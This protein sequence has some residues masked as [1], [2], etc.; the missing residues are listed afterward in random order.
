MKENKQELWGIS[1]HIDIHECNPLKITKGEEIK[2]YIL[3]LCDL[4]KVKAWGEMTLV[5]FGEGEKIAGYSVVQLIETSCLTGHFVDSTSSAY[6]DIFSCNTY[7]HNLAIEYTKKFFETEN[8]TFTVLD[9][10]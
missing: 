3:N 7:D 6:I 2:K 4:L 5:H 9:R 10:K 8:C 1:T